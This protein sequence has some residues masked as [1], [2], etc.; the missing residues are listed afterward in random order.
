LA[1]QR[2]AG[3]VMLAAGLPMQFRSAWLLLMV[4]DNQRI[5]GIS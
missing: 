1:D 5:A 3:L 4:G 2:Y